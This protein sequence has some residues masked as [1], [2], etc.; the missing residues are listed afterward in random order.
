[1]L[2]IVLLGAFISQGLFIVNGIFDIQ[3]A[4]YVVYQG[5]ITVT[6]DYTLVWNGPNRTDYVISFHNGSEEVKLLSNDDIVELLPGDYP[7]S[8]V[9]YSYRSKI[10]VDVDCG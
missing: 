8:I 10:L 4:S 6:T 9:V 1:M 2:C 3:N 5:D 7:N